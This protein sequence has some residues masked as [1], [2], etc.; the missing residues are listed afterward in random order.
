MDWRAICL[1]W[2]FK[3]NNF[4]VGMPACLFAR[5][6]DETLAEERVAGTKGL[7][8]NVLSYHLHFCKNISTVFIFFPIVEGLYL[9]YI[10]F[11]PL[12]PMLLCLL[13]LSLLLF[14]TPLP[15]RLN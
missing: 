4:V 6:G 11:L 8:E 1:L 14:L 12:S 13:F 10:L 9:L 15:F 3:V 7:F 2:F 5:S